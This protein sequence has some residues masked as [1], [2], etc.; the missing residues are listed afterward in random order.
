MLLF[1]AAAAAALTAIHRHS[2]FIPTSLS[3]LAHDMSSSLVPSALPRGILLTNDDGPPGKYA[4]FLLPFSRALKSRLRLLHTQSSAAATATATSSPPPALFVCTPSDQQSWVGKAIT[5]FAQVK[6][7]TNYPPPTATPAASTTSPPPAAAY[8]TADGDDVGLWATVDGTPSTTAN[9]ALHTLAPFPIDLCISG[10]NLG[11]NTGRSFVLSSGTVGAALECAFAGVRS[12][13]LSF[14]YFDKLSSYS[15]EQVGSACEVAVDVL[16]RLWSEW[17]EGV[18]VFNVN[19]PL[20][21]ARDVAVYHTHLLQDH[22]GAIYAPA[23][24]RQLSHSL[25]ATSTTTG[26]TDTV[27]D[28]SITKEILS[29][30]L[31][32]PSA[33]VL[34]PPS[35]TLPPSLNG[36]RPQPLLTSPMAVAGVDSRVSELSYGI[37]YRFN[38]DMFREWSSVKGYVG[39]DYA[40]VKD[41]YVSVS[42]LKSSFI[43]C[44]WR[45]TSY[46]RFGED[47][48]SSAGAASG[49]D[50]IDAGQ[51]KSAL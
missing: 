44:D 41:G 6:A 43:E 46:G 11:R 38:I 37:E 48:R 25:P 1:G 15:D 10:P 33:A 8:V 31:P 24:Y 50:G 28:D 4:P 2:L 17:A 12:V 36:F 35:P 30:P 45:S 23:G 34:P 22:Y 16:L 18:E 13:A 49:S 5:R 20:G 7:H 26:D 42:A 3:I 40:V 27:S 47:R 19:V 39:S 21:C 9:V 32:L 29:S 51:R 14:A